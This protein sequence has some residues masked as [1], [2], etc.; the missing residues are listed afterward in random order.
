MPDFNPRRPQFPGLPAELPLKWLVAA[1][2]LTLVLG[3]LARGVYTVG[4]E[5]VGVIQRFGRFVG[6]V[7]PGLRFKLPFGIDTV[8]ILPV[9]RQ[10]KMEFGFATTASTNPD[11]SSRETDRESDMVTGDLNAAHVEW[12]VQYEID[13][14]EQYLFNNREPG[15]TLRDLSESVMREVV[16]DRTVD[17]VLT[18]GRQGIENEAIAKLTALVGGLHLGLRV[19]QVQLKNVHPPAPVQRSFEEVNRAQQEREQ[20]I[21]QANGEYNKVVP[22]AAGEAE[23]RTREAE[24]YAL[25]RVNEAEGDV[26]RFRALLEQYEKSPDVTRRR[27]YLETMARVL[28]RLGGKVILDADASQ[29]L[30]LLNLRQTEPAP[31][32]A[33]VA[34]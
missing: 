8:T 15:P 7:G 32:A 23:R 17:E 12:V 10:L 22:R 19:Q 29:F 20:M 31:P 9:K 5:S 24:G 33:G 27:L 26:A 34:P 13:D 25:E 1:A 2:V 11:Q 21:N 3:G 14:P 28:P 4:P 30:P 18:I 6:T 16:G